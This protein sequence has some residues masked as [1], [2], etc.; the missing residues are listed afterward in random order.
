[1]QK[2]CGSFM[3]FL[4]LEPY[5]ERKFSLLGSSLTPLISLKK[6]QRLQVLLTL[7]KESI[8]WVV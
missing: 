1:M 5:K 8:A 2:Q 4:T 3:A 6:Y 7:N